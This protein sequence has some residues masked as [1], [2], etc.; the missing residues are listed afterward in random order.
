[1]T[2]PT[3]GGSPLTPLPGYPT[4]RGPRTQREA[5]DTVAALARLRR[6]LRDVLSTELPKRVQP[7]RSGTAV[8]REEREALVWAILRFWMKRW[9]RTAKRS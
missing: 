7:Q 6:R 3:N 4:G 8:G 1:M 2:L 9:P 5:P